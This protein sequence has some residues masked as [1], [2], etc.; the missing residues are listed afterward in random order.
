[1][2]TKDEYV[3]NA[4]FETLR[5]PN[6]ADSNFEPANVVDVIDKLAMAGYCISKAIK[7]DAAPGKDEYGGTV[8]S[9]TE[10]VMGITQGLSMIASAI[11]DLAQAVRETIPDSPPPKIAT[12]E[13]AKNW[14]P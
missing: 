5:S 4:I 12:Q 11:S 14:K 8:D 13:D 3:A 1:M 10:S 9:L 7:A 2:T 6:V